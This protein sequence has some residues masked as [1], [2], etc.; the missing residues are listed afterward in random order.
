MLAGGILPVREDRTQPLHGSGQVDGE[1]LVPQETGQGRGVEVR[2]RLQHLGI[3]L[4]PGVIWSMPPP[5]PSVLLQSGVVQLKER[6]TH[7][8]E[9]LVRV[10]PR[11]PGLD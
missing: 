6:K 3:D 7:S 11:G 10:P 9:S 1:D 5:V 2:V 4:V 8:V